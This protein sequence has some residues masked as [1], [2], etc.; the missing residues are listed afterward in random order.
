MSSKRK[1][2]EFSTDSKGAGEKPAREYIPGF[3]PPVN[4]KNK[5]RAK[6]KPNNINWTKKRVRTI[7]RR[8]KHRDSLPANVL[9]DME[10]ELEHH[11]G[12]IND[13][14]DQKHRKKMIKQYHMVRFFERKKADRLAKQIRTQLENTTDEDEISKL[15]ADL[16]I[17]ETDAL[18]AKYHPHRE[19][20]ISLYPVSSLGLGEK[21]KQKKEDASSA[22]RHLHSERPPMWSVIEEAAKSGFPALKELMERTSVPGLKRKALTTAKDGQSKGKSTGAAAPADSRKGNGKRQK[23][24]TSSS[25]S[26]SDDA[27]DGGFFEEE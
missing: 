12:K 16:H 1:F 4:K 23:L 3:H 11:K 7:E 2:S 20:Y 27:S 18:Y 21:D 24:S 22:A 26:N 14:S 13:L 10:R 15:K 6:I 25:E 17:A 5:N 19:R 9:N 8:L